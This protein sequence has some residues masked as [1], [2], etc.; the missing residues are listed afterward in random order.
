MTY[1]DAH[2]STLLLELEKELHGRPIPERNIAMVG[3]RFLLM[4][5]RWFGAARGVGIAVLVFGQHGSW[6]EE[7]QHAH[8]LEQHLP[9]NLGVD[10]DLPSRGFPNLPTSAVESLAISVDKHATRMLFGLDAQLTRITGVEDLR[11]QM[12]AR[13]ERLAYPLIV[14]PSNACSYSVASHRWDHY[15]GTRG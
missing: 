11:E 15:E 9:I 1:Q 8:L 14:K 13:N 6:L 3:R 10:K 12:E 2:K 7:S 4:M 5:E